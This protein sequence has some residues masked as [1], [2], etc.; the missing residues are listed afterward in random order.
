MTY[1]L[2]LDPVAQSWDLCDLSLSQNVPKATV[3]G[4]AVLYGRAV[5]LPCVCVRVSG[6]GGDFR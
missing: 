1:W 6:L 3:F 5:V 4:A 2:S